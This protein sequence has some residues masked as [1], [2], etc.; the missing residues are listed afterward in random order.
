MEAE[1]ALDDYLRRFVL[2]S[3]SLTRNYAPPLHPRSV[4]ASPEDISLFPLPPPLPHPK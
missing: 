4:R 3:E 2:V 1:A